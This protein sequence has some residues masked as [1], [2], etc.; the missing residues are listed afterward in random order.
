M[1]RMLGIGP[2]T[3]GLFGEM[4]KID[5]ATL[6]RGVRNGVDRGVMTLRGSFKRV[7]RYN[8]PDDSSYSMILFAELDLFRIRCRWGRDPKK[9]GN[10]SQIGTATKRIWIMEVM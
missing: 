2:S 1:A 4:K 8:R 5:V 7:R 10:S 9:N 3:T 6:R